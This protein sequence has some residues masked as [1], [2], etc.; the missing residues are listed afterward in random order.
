[1][2]HHDHERGILGSFR[3]SGI[4]AVSTALKP[5]DVDEVERSESAV[6]QCACNRACLKTVQLSVLNGDF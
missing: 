3:S 4:M 1:M 6:A 2:K 5:W